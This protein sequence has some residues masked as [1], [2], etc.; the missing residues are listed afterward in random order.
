MIFGQPGEGTLVNTANKLY[1]ILEE[2]VEEIKQ[3]VTDA[4]VASFDETGMRS[5]GKTQWLHVASTE[6]L[7]YYAIHDKRGEKLH[8]TSVFCQIS[9]E[10]P[11][12]TTGSHTIASVTGMPEWYPLIW[13]P[14]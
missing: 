4:D 6:R 12:M 7:T 1:N 14:D 5:E 3:Q 10:Q 9:R 2:P 11:Y 13:R 8:G